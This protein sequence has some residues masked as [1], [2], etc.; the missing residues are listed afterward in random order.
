M[1]QKLLAILVV[2]VSVNVAW[3]QNTV[4]VGNAPRLNVSGGATVPTIGSA[5][6][7]G[8]FSSSGTPTFVP[9]DVTSNSVVPIAAMQ[10]TAF[11]PHQPTILERLASMLPFAA[12]TGATIVAPEAVILHDNL[13]NITIK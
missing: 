1:R 9:V 8:S 12:K 11:R 2:G 4:T 6:R 10:R 3:S 5:P 7:L 13:P